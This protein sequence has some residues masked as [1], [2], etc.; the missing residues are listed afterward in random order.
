VIQVSRNST[1]HNTANGVEGDK[2][3]LYITNSDGVRVRDNT[4]K[5]NG[6]F[7]VNIGPTSNNNRLF[8]N[9]ITGNPTDLNNEGSGNCGSGNTIGTTSGNPL[10][11]C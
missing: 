2:S 4:I 11:P 8:D 1:H 7:G 10:V 6:E 3:G 5:S 9:V